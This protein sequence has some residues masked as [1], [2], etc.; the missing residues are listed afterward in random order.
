MPLGTA[1]PEQRPEAVSGTPCR[2]GGSEELGSLRPHQQRQCLQ[3]EEGG[4]ELPLCQPGHPGLLLVKVTNLPRTS[5][6]EKGLLHLLMKVNVTPKQQKW[7]G[8][9]SAVTVGFHEANS[10]VLCHSPS[11]PDTSPSSGC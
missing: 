5:Y 10:G 2:P 4:G 11:C 3:G 7:G 1:R 9:A 6:G 8:C